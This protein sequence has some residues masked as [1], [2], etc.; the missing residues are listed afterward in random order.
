MKSF[1][2]IFIAVVSGI[3]AGGIVL[4]LGVVVFISLISG[5]FSSDVEF[6]ASPNSVLR[7]DLSGRE[8]EY[9]I[10]NPFLSLLGEEG[11]ELSLQKQLQA[12]HRAKVDRNI[13]GIFLNAKDWSTG[14]ASAQ[15]L[16]R[17]LADFK[18]CG[19]FVVAYADQYTQSAY[20]L[21]SVAD[22]VILNPQGVIDLHGLYSSR[23]FYLGLME[24]LGITAQIF[25]VGAY[26]S[27]VEPF[28]RV[29]M[30]KESR[31]QT[32]LYLSD[33][34]GFLLNEIGED[35]GIVSSVLNEEVNGVLSLRGASH[36]LEMGLVDSLLYRSDV[37]CFLK[38]LAGVSQKDELKLASVDEV[39]SIGGGVKNGSSEKIAVLYAEGEIRDFVPER[40]F[41]SSE[42]YI[43]PDFMGEV[44]KLKDDESVK[45]VVLRVNS[46]GGS[47]F[48]SEQIWK[49]LND[50]KK[51][52]PFIVSMGDVAASGGY[53]ISAGANLI[54]AEPTTITGS[55]GIFGIIPDF[56]GLIDK[57]GI[58]LDGVGTNDHADFPSFS[59]PMDSTERRL[60]QANVE[61]G[62][63][64]FLD[65]CSIGRG[66]STDSLALIAEGRVWS[67][68]RASENGL[69]DVLGDLNRA[70][71][72][73]A[74][75]AQISQYEVVYY[76]KEKD[77]FSLLFNGGMGKGI[78]SS[79]FFPFNQKY[80]NE[81]LYLYDL[82][83][84]DRIQARLPFG[85]NIFL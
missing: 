83:D 20:Y 33:Q 71:E 30:S 25:K 72:L 74:D 14:L 3:I 1:F 45:A 37:E 51:V 48:L 22:W 19:K 27:A 34:W 73:A 24:K 60:M 17:A 13:S 65:R 54:V 39:C 85:T 42:R 78:I 67:G 75:Y 84:I 9:V 46:P 52:K 57:T 36:Y 76:P 4:F 5:V 32:L 50:L 64:L 82:K 21:C 11:K 58:V 61:R 28:M 15:S 68:I 59:D 44:Q 31:E 63:S 47:A 69:V 56:S 18:G 29:G 53:Y 43:T 41:Y 7:I 55:I 12:I 8:R 49:E 40:G 10:S 77:F 80:F 79:L 66:I 81:L 23:G 26:K 35:R 6:V 16:R 62:Y 2:K 70:I 38:D